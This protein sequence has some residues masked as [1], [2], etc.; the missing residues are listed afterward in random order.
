[1][2][3]KH[4][5]PEQRLDPK[6]TVPNTILE[7]FPWHWDPMEKMHKDADCFMKNI[8]FDWKGLED[9]AIKKCNEHLTPQKYWWYD[10]DN[11]A[12]MHGQD[13]VNNMPIKEQAEMA[14][15]NNTHNIHNTQYF[16]IANE[17]LGEYYEPLSKLFPNLKEDKMG[18]SLFV[19]MPGHTIWSHVDTYSSFIR[20][21]GDV[22]ADYS[23]LRRYMVFVKDWDWGH[24]F[25]Y[26]NHC[27]NQWKAGDCWDLVP[28]IY[29]GSANAGV[30]PK[31]TIHW[32]GEL[33][34]E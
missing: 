34:D 10:Y 25:H 18:I 29:H 31:L 21:T 14:L 2:K 3:L 16:K 23:V 24:F 17:E 6:E 13:N 33:K 8:E 22:K 12:V 30:N 9:F 32:S 27:F 15:K 11:D 5:I 20:R 26:G 1:M 7:Q 4:P 28:G 19:Q